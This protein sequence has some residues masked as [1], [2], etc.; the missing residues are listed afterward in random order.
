[1]EVTMKA[2]K[3]VVWFHYNKPY[4]QKHKI[5]MW[6]VHYRGVCHIVEKIVCNIPTFSKN[7]KT[8]PRVVM[9]GYAHEVSMDN[10]VATIS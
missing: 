8:Q 5:D 2:K 3:Y 6:S 1:M 10:G 7:N 4:S 9:K